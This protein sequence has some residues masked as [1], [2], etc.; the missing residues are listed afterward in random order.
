MTYGDGVTNLNINKLIAFHLKSK[1]TATVTAV[2]PPARFGELKINQN[3]VAKFDRK[4]S[5]KFRLD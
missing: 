4:K 5:N 2:R 3:I 1:K